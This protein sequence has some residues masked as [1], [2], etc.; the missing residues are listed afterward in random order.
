VTES[1]RGLSLVVI[2]GG[3]LGQTF[4]ACLAASGGDVTLVTTTSGRQRLI[5]AGSIRVSGAVTIA[6]P[7]VGP[8]AIQATTTAAPPP[9]SVRVTDDPADAPAGARLVFA[10]KAHQLDA[11]A[12]L[13]AGSP[14]GGSAPWVLGVQ[15]GLLKDDVLRRWFGPGSL[16]SATL[17]SA[18][19]EAD[20]GVTVS[21]TGPT[22]VGALEAGDVARAGHLEEVRAA[23]SG[24]GLPTE[25][26]GDI[27]AITWAKAANAAG[28][29]AVASLTRLP[30]RT[31][32]QRPSLASAFVGLVREVGRIANANGVDIVDVPGLPIGS[33][34][35]GPLESVVEGLVSRAATPSNAPSIFPSMTQD[36]LAGRSTEVEEVIGDLVRRAEAASV[37]VPM[38]TLALQL[39]RGVVQRPVAERP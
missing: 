19:R 22:Y 4:A 39:L 15:N 38:L 6:V 1:V 9:G 23:F 13:M 18:Q 28:A 2:G 10:T 37:P 21:A 30:A 3:A 29:F 34:L 36:I 16:G 20:R 27:L 35:A 32:L 24:S 17:V 12:S 8:T 31:M 5:G 33:Y 25:V 11:A 7:V 26:R 14:A